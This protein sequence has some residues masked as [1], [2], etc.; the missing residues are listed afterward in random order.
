MKL[1]EIKN[2][3]EARTSTS[4]IT[5]HTEDNKFIGIFT[6]TLGDPI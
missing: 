1:I 4:V 3:Y 6:D 2:I 5:W